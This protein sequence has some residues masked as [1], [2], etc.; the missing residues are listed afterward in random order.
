[1]QKF[2]RKKVTAAQCGLHPSSVMRKA[3]DPDDDFPA[4]VY[5]G[6]PNSRHRPVVFPEDEIGAWQE[7]RMAERSDRTEELSKE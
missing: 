7:R 1:M 4:P 5:L 2:L 6:D 3:L